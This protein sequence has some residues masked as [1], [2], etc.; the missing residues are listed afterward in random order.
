M[1]FNGSLQVYQWKLLNHVAR[2]H[3]MTLKPA[4]LSYKC[5]VCTAT[6]GM[7]KQFENHVYSAHSVVA[8]RVMDKKAP[9]VPRPPQQNDAILKPLKIN[10]EITIIPQPARPRPGPAS[11]TGAIPAWLQE[12]N[13]PS[14][15]H[16]CE[17]CEATFDGPAGFSQYVSHIRR[18]HLRRCGVK[19]C[20]LDGCP[21]C[22]QRH[23][24]QDMLDF[25]EE[26][27]EGVD[28]I[29]LSDDEV[30]I[31]GQG[32]NEI[33]ITKVSC[34][35]GP[36]RFKQRLQQSHNVQVIELEDSPVKSSNNSESSAGKE[37]GEDSLTAVKE[38]LRRR[39][40]LE[41]SQVDS[42]CSS[43]QSSDDMP[44]KKKRRND[45]D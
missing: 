12:K 34:A 24:T 30:V 11:R 32:R 35:P 43:P 28:V 45:D 14:K 2:D 22:K 6:F 20:R 18:R 26:Q 25:L 21:T 42:E 10:D 23:V 13:P 4:H 40:S 7:Y 36:R 31:A 39:K 33:T 37:N 3:N 8:K 29:E 19:L 17:N 44:A 41:I 27:K 5:T 1:Y 15:V 38:R 9:Q 16:A